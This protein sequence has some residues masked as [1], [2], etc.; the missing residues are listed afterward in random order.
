MGPVPWTTLSN[1]VK[2]PLLG[3]GT[4]L[5]RGHELEN[6]LRIALDNGYRLIDTAEFY[7]NEEFIGNVIEEYVEKGKIKRSEVF[8]MTKL[9]VY[10]QREPKRFIEESLK[11]LKMDYIDLYLIHNPMGFMKTEGEDSIKI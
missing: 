5:A 3:L 8:I 7:K 6:A 4:S 11:K 2:M 10:G 1:G 9:P